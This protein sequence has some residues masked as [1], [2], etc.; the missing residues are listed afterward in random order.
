MKLTS[1]NELY[2]NFPDERK[3]R[4]Q[5]KV[6]EMNKIIEQHNEPEQVTIDGNIIAWLKQSG[7]DYQERVN[8]I[9]SE[10][11]LEDLSRHADT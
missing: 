8:D 1:F 6:A 9:L 5:A 7:D 2:E 4:I 10:M 11:M 3:A